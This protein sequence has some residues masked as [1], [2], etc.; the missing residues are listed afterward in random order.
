MKVFLSKF[1]LFLLIV[2]PLV[3][4]SQEC[5]GSAVNNVS[6]DRFYY[7]NASYNLINN[8]V[9]RHYASISL[10]SRY[11]RKASKAS[12]ANLKSSRKSRRCR[13]SRKCG[14]DS[15]DCNDNDKV[16]RKAPS[17]ACKD[18]NDED[19]APRKDLRKACKDCN[20]SKDCYDND[21]VPRKAPRKACEDCKDRKRIIFD[22]LSNLGDYTSQITCSTSSSHTSLQ[23]QATASQSLEQVY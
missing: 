17:K 11:S 14:L 18:C 9:E 20:D 3:G 7:K 23:A 4:Q 2:L 8:L 12:K 10:S 19:K 22:F 1:C 21:K 5:H 13:K 16:H 6:I 15:K